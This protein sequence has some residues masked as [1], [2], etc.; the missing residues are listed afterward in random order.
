MK[1]GYFSITFA[2]LSFCVVIANCGC[3]GPT[4]QNDL[5]LFEE[6]VGNIVVSKDGSQVRHTFVVDN[7]TSRE[8]TLKLRE[9]SC[10]CFLV[11]EK[12]ITIEPGDER[13]IEVSSVLR[14]DSGEVTWTALYDTDSVDIPFVCLR[15][16]AIAVP[17]LRTHPD[18]VP[19]L[20]FGQG[21]D[22]CTTS[23]DIELNCGEQELPAAISV[24]SDDPALSVTCAITHC[25]PPSTAGE[26]LLH[27]IATMKKPSHVLWYASPEDRVKRLV[28][29]VNGKEVGTVPV[30]WIVE[31]PVTANPSRLFINGRIEQ[32]EPSL[33]RL[34]SGR[35]FSVKSVKST[36]LTF[37]ETSSP[38]TRNLHTFA[39]SI[40]P[41]KV[42]YKGSDSG[43]F[44]DV[45]EIA[46]DH[47]EQSAVHLEAFVLQ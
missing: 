7:P 26:N 15:L 45:I 4:L 32:A 10:G 44:V 33:V 21:D 37:V 13:A 34:E 31:T 19:P 16:H 1:V 40:D 46:I 14:E 27:C 25:P 11:A 17:R 24:K 6:D 8:I 3:S 9:R 35:A 23:F 42:K 22:I 43:G 29:E 5:A 47:P 38:G 39:C 41:A 20:E 18:S 28:V 30:P 12:N 36:R 2:G